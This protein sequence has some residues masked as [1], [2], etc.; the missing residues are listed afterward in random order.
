MLIDIKDKV[1]SVIL[2][3][4]DKMSL[5]HRPYFEKDCHFC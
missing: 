2:T 1:D 3:L 4:H 5:T